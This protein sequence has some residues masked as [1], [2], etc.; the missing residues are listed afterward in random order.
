MRYASIDPCE[1]CNGNNIGLSVFVQGCPFRCE[2]C[3]NRQAWDFSGGYE[4][5]NQTESQFIKLL[6]KPYI[7]RLSILG[8][9]PLADQNLPLTQRLIQLARH[10]APQKKIWT[11][12]GYMVEEIIAPNNIVLNGVKPNLTPQEAERLKNDALRYNIFLGC[13]YLVDGRF[14]IEHMDLTYSR[15]KFAGST[16][17]RIID[18]HKS[19]QSKQVILWDEA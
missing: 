19:V 14:E 7:Q 1:M 18:V 2:G 5:T 8:G 16:N 9:E 12:T 6:T 11:Y 3:F 15:V 17:Q 4:W 13:D 10:I